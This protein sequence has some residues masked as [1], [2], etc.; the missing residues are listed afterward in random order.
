[1]VRGGPTRTLEGGRMP[2]RLVMLAFPSPERAIE[3]YNSAEYQAAV[4]I[5]LKSADTEV[6]LPTGHED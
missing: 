5:R 6:F 3:W 4:N 1:L 2:S